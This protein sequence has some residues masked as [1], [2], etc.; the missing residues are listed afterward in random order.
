MLAVREIFGACSMPMTVRSRDDIV[1]QASEGGRL[2]GPHARKAR[3]DSVSCSHGGVEERLLQGRW[4]SR[5]QH[6]AAAVL[7]LLTSG[8]Q[9]SCV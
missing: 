6:P 4:E 8:Y 7:A 2:A 5:T 3:M 1:S 9:P